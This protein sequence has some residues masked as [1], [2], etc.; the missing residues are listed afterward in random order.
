MPDAIW[1]EAR[2]R[3]RGELPEKDFETWIGPLRA[4]RWAEHQLTLEV[5]S[6]F[7]RD[8]VKRHYAATLEQAVSQASGGVATVAFI[9]NR[10][11]DAGGRAGPRR[12]GAPRADKA[13][14]L[15]LPP[16]ARYTFDSFVVGRSNQVA[17][18]AAQA[19][20][21]QPGSRFNPLFVYGG[22]GLGKTHLLNAVG[23]GVMAARA[24][25]RVACVSAENFV[26]AMIAGL[27]GNGMDR[28]RQRFRYIETLIVDDI[29]FLAG[30]RRSQEEFCHTF[31]ALHDGRK[32]IVLASD[33]APHEM[34]GLEETLRNRFAS[35]LLAEIEAPDAALRRALVERKAAALG[36]EIVPEVATLLAEEWC[37]SVRALEGALTRLEAYATLAGRTITPAVVRQALGPAP[38]ARGRQTSLGRIIGEVCQHYQ[39]TRGEIGSKRRTARVALPR[40]VAMYLCRHHTDVPLGQ[41]GAELGGRDHS[42]VV[43][44]LAAIERRLRE[45]ATLRQAVTSLRAR[46]A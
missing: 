7:C 38:G 37:E 12:A 2:R 21:A 36:V 44:A 24:A 10:T 42:T 1:L 32:Q 19:V 30:K 20:V 18:G 3:L 43:H 15:A 9:V 17:H 26:N 28:F 6:I 23:N 35:G 16:A 46:I 5:P 41:I 31:N 14:T 8:W 4:T 22:C 29:Q 39:L 25:A 27:K 45:D 34:P 11:L 13:A 40:Q 33:R